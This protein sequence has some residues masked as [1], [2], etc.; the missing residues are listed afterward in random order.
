MAQ[1]DANGWHTIE[2]PPEGRAAHTSRRRFLKTAAAA[3]GLAGI[4]F[5]VGRGIVFGGEEPPTLA[6]APT[7]PELQD[8]ADNIA[9]GGPPKDGIPSVDEPQFL[10]A[11]QARFLSDDDV[12]FGIVRGGEARAYPQLVL[13]WHEIVN[14]SFSD[15]PLSITYCPLTGSAVAFGGEAPTGEPYTFG[16][17]GNLVNSNL[18]MYDRQ[19]DSEWPQILGKA[20]TGPAAGDALDEVPVEWTTWGRWRAAHPETVVL[21]TET[22][23]VRDYTRDPYGSYT[24]LGGYYEEE[25]LIFSVLH[26]DD[27]FHT[28]EVF[29]GAKLGA[30]KAAVRK[31]T[32]AE[33]GV[34]EIELDD[35]PVVFL[36]DPDLDPRGGGGGGGR[37]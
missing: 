34:V 25:R 6:D 16:T 12:V 24:P 21:S 30:E 36:H 35:E 7:P 20:I 5:L 23:Y 1:H 32:L 10:S 2:E 3:G 13:V 28:K 18:L 31:E 19:S 37:G 33:R 8:F 9:R 26:E 15:G 11:D 27:R 17:T 29:I 14:D 4:G 22:G